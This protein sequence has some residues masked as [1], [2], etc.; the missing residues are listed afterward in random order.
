VLSITSN[1]QI[2]I[3]HSH[4]TTD[5]PVK[6]TD[7]RV[8]TLRRKKL[9]DFHMIPT[10]RKIEVTRMGNKLCKGTKIN[11]KSAQRL[12]MHEDDQKEGRLRI[13]KMSSYVDNRQEEG[14]KMVDTRTEWMLLQNEEVQA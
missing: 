1:D 14:S 13:K 11:V 4:S 2:K 7:N 6:T 8:A 12:I 3:N 10:E 5:S 9:T